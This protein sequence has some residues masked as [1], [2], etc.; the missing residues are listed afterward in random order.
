MF[1]VHV[2]FKEQTYQQYLRFCNEETCAKYFLLAF[3]P[4][5]EFVIAPVSR[6]GFQIAQM[7]RIA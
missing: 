5:V 1:Q 2:L 6:L 3:E 4:S 7:T